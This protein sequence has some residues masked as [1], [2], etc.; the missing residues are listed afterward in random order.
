MCNLKV[1]IYGKID[2]KVIVTLYEC[3]KTCVFDFWSRGH[4]RI[5]VL[6]LRIKYGA[7]IFIQ[8]GVIDIF[9]KLKMAASA[10]LDLLGEPWDH[11]R[12]E[13]TLVVRGP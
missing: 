12:V 1:E 9:P 4:L 7:D 11:S 8:S 2:V 6:H 3:K 5:A 10:M 13:D